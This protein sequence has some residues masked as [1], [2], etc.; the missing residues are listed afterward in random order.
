MAR[1]MTREEREA[2]LM[3]LAAIGL[4]GK[5]ALN[6]ILLNHKGGQGPLPTDINEVIRKI[7]VHE[8]SEQEPA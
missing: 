2:E 8:Y 5:T 1:C 4:R 7:L 6:A 3:Q